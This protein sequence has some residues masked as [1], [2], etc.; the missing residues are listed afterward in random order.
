M[1]RAGWV[2]GREKGRRGGGIEWLPGYF[3][4]KSR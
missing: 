2:E 1:E 4:G 3:C